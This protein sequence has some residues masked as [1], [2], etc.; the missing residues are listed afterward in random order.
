[1]KILVANLGSTSFKFKLFEMAVARVAAEGT[2][3][4]TAGIS[5]TAQEL[6]A[7]SLERIGEPNSD[8]RL[9]IRD[10]GDAAQGQTPA[11]DHAAALDF[12][13]AQLLEQQVLQSA[14]ELD[15]IGLKAVHG[16]RYSGVQIVDD[17]IFAAMEEMNCVAPVHNPMYVAAMRQLAQ[18]FPK[19]PLVA[20]FETG[21]HQTNAPAQTHYAVPH[22]WHGQYGVRRWG[23]H[24]ASHRYIAERAAE[25]LPEAERVISLHLG[26]SSSV[27]AIRGGRSVDVSMGM[28][29][30]TGIA[31]ATRCGD[32]DPFAL[33]WLMQQTGQSVDSLLDEMASAGGLLGLSGLSSDMRDLQAAADQDDE[34][35]RLAL[36]VYVADV[37]RQLGAMLVLLGGADALVFTGGTGQ[38]AAGIRQ[39]I[40]Q[41]LE[42]LGI[43]AT[44]SVAAGQAEFSFHAADSKTQLWVIPTNE[45]L[46]VARQAAAALQDPPPRQRI[47]GD[48]AM[49]T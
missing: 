20:A 43:Q 26:G 12:F 46:V 41:G 13:I 31:Q 3:V 45:E 40:C 22:A 39:A 16:G 29:P 2:T 19:V 30:Q 11:P 23:F 35:A 27:C 28:S 4:Q 47:F 17:E 34:R 24:G 42:E 15:G 33:P 14:D 49:E 44:A 1:M 18:A 36:D 21:F 10:A 37:R 6:A 8:F 32:F 25:I 5:E 9:S 7:G 38:N 48:E